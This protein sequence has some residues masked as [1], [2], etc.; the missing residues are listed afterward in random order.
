MIYKQPHSSFIP[1]AEEVSVVPNVSV[2]QS[3][4]KK[5]LGKGS[6]VCRAADPTQKSNRFIFFFPHMS[7]SFLELI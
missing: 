5:S 2:L 1:A 7:I 6:A 3:L 4:N